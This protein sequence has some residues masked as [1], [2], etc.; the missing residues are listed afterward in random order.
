MIEITFSL[1]SGIVI[2]LV[3]G[4][5]T[6]YYFERRESIHTRAQNDEFRRQL[7]VLKTTLYSVAAPESAPRDA[8]MRPPDIASA[9]TERA[10]ATQDP[11]GRVQRAALVTHFVGRGFGSTEVEAAIDSMCNSG[12]AQAQGKWVQLR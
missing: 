1:I 9:V 2:G 3:S 10:L 6:G 5:V 7:S 4:L 12:A 8:F 11:S